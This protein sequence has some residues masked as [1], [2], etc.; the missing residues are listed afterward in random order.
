MARVQG[1]Y[2][3]V[4]TEADDELMANVFQKCKRR[5]QAIATRDE[6]LLKGRRKKRRIE[7]YFSAA[8]HER[9]VE[10]VPAEC[11]NTSTASAST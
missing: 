6:S 4:Y 1:A 2:R 3:I 7:D 8:E 9:E 10:D 11:L 5:F